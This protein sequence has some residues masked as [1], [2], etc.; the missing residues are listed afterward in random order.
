MPFFY[1]PF[2]MSN[3]LLLKALRGE[4]VERFPVWLMR[5]AG[6]YMPQYR[7]LRKK[8]KDFLE[9]CSNVELATEVTLLPEKLLGVDA[10]ILFSDILVPL[11]PL[12]VEVEFKNGEGPILKAPPLEGWRDFNPEE[13][14]FVFD[15]I[16]RVK[17][18]SSLPLIGFSGAP[19]T[20]GAYILEGRTSK[21]FKEIRKLFYSDRRKFHLLMERLSQ[22]VVD[23][24]SKQLEAG[25]DVIQIFDSWTYV[26][27]PELFKEYVPHLDFVA[28]ELKRRYAAPVI[29][30]FRGSGF[31]YREAFKLPFDAFSVDWSL[32]MEVALKKLPNKAVQGNL[33]PTLL[34]APDGIIKEET[35]KLLKTVAENRRTLYVFNLGHGL[36]PEMELNKV[37]LLVDTVKSFYL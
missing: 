22:M 15:T 26:S 5:Q 3:S 8:A 27:S 28:T 21:D 1:N 24:L 10:L 36:S 29:Y 25:A 33:D 37:K 17:Q 2:L 19:F 32:P 23:Y 12:G 30:F 16:K 14:E 13:V 4:P 7:E 6:R 35:L 18:K 20:L 9:F 11:I 31:L 34:F